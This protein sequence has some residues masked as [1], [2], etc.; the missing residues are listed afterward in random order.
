MA[1]YSSAVSAGND[2]FAGD[3]NKIRQDIHLGAKISETITPAAAV[4]IDLSDVSKGNVKQITIDE[5]TTISFSGITK[6]P[7]VFFLRITQDSTGGWA[8]TFNQTGIK[9][10]D[11]VS[12]TISVSANEV[13]GLMFIVYSASDWDCYFAG[14]E[15]S[16]PA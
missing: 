12:P 13:T 9:F 8:V 1:P 5:D 15:L 10:P 14:F 4:T 16:E 11:G 6:Y 3:L 7:T 2:V